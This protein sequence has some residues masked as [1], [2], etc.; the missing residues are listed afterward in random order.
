MDCC[1]II[2]YFKISLFS[3]NLSC[4]FFLLFFH[5]ST[6]SSPTIKPLIWQLC[7]LGDSCTACCPQIDITPKAVCDS[8]TP[9]PVLEG[10][11]NLVRSAEIFPGMQSIT[12]AVKIVSTA[13]TNLNYL[14][15][16]KYSDP[17]DPLLQGTLT[18]RKTSG[19]Y[20][21]DTP[22]PITLNRLCPCRQP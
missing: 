1:Q 18:R 12:S 8:S 5:S 15:A 14:P 3:C 22:A 13:A 19:L 20:D 6:V 21:C 10:I 16:W 11:G 17:P 7:R 4:Y 9:L 2:C